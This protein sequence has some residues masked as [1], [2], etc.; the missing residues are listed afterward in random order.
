M[1]CGYTRCLTRV[2]K[3]TPRG[4]KRPRVFPRCSLDFDGLNK[5]LFIVL[6]FFGFPF[7]RLFHFYLLEPSRVRGLRYKV[8]L[9]VRECFRLA[10]TDY[11]FKVNM[12]TSGTPFRGRLGLT[13]RLFDHERSLQ[14]H[15]HLPAFLGP[16]VELVKLSLIC[17]VCMC[18]S[19]WSRTMQQR[20]SSPSWPKR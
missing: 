3:A 7:T 17:S 6:R 18:R 4:V 12:S 14:R 8:F 11:V 2:S 19:L 9:C 5:I 16:D 10:S 13:S 20:R 15:R 1:N